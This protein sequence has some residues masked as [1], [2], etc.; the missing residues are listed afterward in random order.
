MTTRTGRRWPIGGMPPMVKPVSS[1]ASRAVARRT[2]GSPVTAASR[3]TSTRFGPGHEAEDRLEAAVVG[4][5]DED[6]RLHDLP[7][8]GA[9]GRG[10]LRGGVG[11]LVEDRRPRGSRPCGRRRR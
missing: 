11:R 9:D 1:L 10:G 3:A 8:L 7:E 5:R 4:R 6:Q 2:S